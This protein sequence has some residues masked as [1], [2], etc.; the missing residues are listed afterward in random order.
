MANA[1]AAAPAAPVDKPAE[2]EKSGSKKKLIIILAAVVAVAGG[3]AAF[4]LRGGDAAAEGEKKAVAKKSEHKLP[5]QYIALDPP[6]V[7]N[8]DAGSSARFLQI[9][10]QLMTRELEM[11]EFLKQ[12]DPVIRNDLLLLLGNVKYEEVQTREGKEALRAS[13]LEAVRHILKAEGA[14]PEKLEAVYFTSFV[15][16]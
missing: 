3:A 2:G 10:V 11:V 6:F 15:M 8:F 5:A 13:A 4:F 12:H 9:T 16:Q 7:V 14:E 1:N